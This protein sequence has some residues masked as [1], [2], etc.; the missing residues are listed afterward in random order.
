M[1]LEW[2]NHAPYIL[3]A[4]GAGAVVFLFLLLEPMRRRRQL[5]QQL[6]TQWRREQLAAQSSAVQQRPEVQA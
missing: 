1:I 2:G 4:Y 6:Q 3:M 5:R